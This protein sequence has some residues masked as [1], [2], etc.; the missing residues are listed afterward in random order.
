[1]K[2]SDYPTFEDTRSEGDYL[3][4]PKT[5]ITNVERLKEFVENDAPLSESSDFSALEP[6]DEAVPGV[7]QKS[8]PGADDL[9]KEDE[10]S[11]FGNFQPDAHRSSSI[12]ESDEI[13]FENPFKKA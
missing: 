7:N 4:S 8:L 9:M 3:D 10:F 2:Y 11:L 5:K 1:M 6:S 13:T 12:S